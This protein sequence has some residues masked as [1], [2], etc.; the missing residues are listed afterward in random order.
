MH[1][2]GR[3]LL[4]DVGVSQNADVQHILRNMFVGREERLK[5]VDRR[6]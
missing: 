2:V 5:A 6:S 1:T 4:V 3:D